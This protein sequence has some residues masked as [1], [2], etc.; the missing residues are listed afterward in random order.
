[1]VRLPPATRIIYDR[2]GFAFWMLHRLMGRDSSL[3]GLRDYMATYRDSRDH[4]L[5]EEYLA[6][7]RR[8]APD[9]AAFDAYVK[10]WFFGTV[11]PQYQVVESGVEREGDRYVVRARLKNVGSG[12]MPLE[13]AATC[14][15]RFP[16][17]RTAANAYQEERAPLRLG[18]GQEQ[19]VVIRCRFEPEK[20]VTDPDVTV[21]MLERQKAEV[22]LRRKHAPKAMAGV[23]VDPI[24]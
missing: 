16:S 8:H 11:V 5:L 21:L 19:T 14:G 22:R 4:P 7:M 23:P 1:M 17:K 24:L 12:V 3:A 10:Q 18:P 6:V 20:L 15:E 13:V 9:P 2:G